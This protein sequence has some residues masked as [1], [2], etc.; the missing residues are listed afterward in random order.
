M[1]VLAFALRSYESV[2]DPWSA[3]PCQLVLGA[4]AVG[5]SSFLTATTDAGALDAYEN[6]TRAA[7]AWLVQG[8]CVQ[9]AAPLSAVEP[10]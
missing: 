7:D 4:I 3:S 9:S 5:T 2:D 1:R 10:G 6:A 8:N